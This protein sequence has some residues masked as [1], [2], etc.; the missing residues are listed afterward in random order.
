MNP[1]QR[2][3][4]DYVVRLVAYEKAYGHNSARRRQAQAKKRQ[5]CINVLCNGDLTDE[6]ALITVQ[7]LL[8]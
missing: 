6:E 8:S 1:A 7:Q 2:E 4:W 3:L 5:V